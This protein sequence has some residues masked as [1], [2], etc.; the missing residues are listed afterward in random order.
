MI[1]PTEINYADMYIK[2][3]SSQNERVRI[4]R[5]PVVLTMELLVWNIYPQKV[6]ASLQNKHPRV[7]LDHPEAKGQG[8]VWSGPK[9]IFCRPAP[10]CR[11]GISLYPK[12]PNSVA[13]NT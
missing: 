3:Q 4:L 2:D 13:S 10:T 9:V 6:R 7:A 1:N 5:E 11:G 12:I 8:M